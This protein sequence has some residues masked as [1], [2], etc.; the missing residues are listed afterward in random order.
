M[1]DRGSRSSCPPPLWIEDLGLLPYREAYRL[2]KEIVSEKRRHPEAPDRLLLVEHPDVYT[3][4]RR[5][6]P[7]PRAEPWVE[8]ERGGEATF[9]NPGQIVAYPILRLREEERDVLGYLRSL[10]EAVRDVLLVFGIPSETRRGATGVW[11]GGGRKKIASIGVA[12]SSWITFH[13]VALNVENDL[14]GFS[15]ITPCGFSADVMT[16]LARELGPRCP[17]LSSVKTALALAIASRSRRL[18][19]LRGGEGLDTVEGIYGKEAR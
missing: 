14:S 10:E 3:Y 5:A 9:H 13:G 17:S 2:Q 7:G 16:S 15:R 1:T 11:V 6:T 19:L 12:L 4:G 18:P 8:I